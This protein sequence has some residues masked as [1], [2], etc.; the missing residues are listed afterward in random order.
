MQRKRYLLMWL[1]GVLPCLLLATLASPL[2]AQPAGTT[3]GSWTDPSGSGLTIKF[4]TPNTYE[5]CTS[6]DDRLYTEGIPANWSLTG[7]VDVYWAIP[8]PSGGTTFEKIR[9]YP[10]AQNGNLDLTIT[11]P[12]ASTWPDLSSAGNPLRE[13][14]VS[15]SILVR[16]Q[17]RREVSW[18]GNDLTGA[19]SILGP[20]QVWDVICLLPPNGNTPTPTPTNTPT[21]GTAALGDRVWNDTNRNGVQ[22]IGEPGVGGVTVELLATCTGSTVLATR[23]TNVNG[24]YLFNNLTAGQYRVR[25]TLPSGFSAFSPKDAIA[26]DD[27]DSDVN[28]V[29]VTDCITLNNGEQNYRVDAGLLSGA[30]TPTPTN[31]TV[32]PLGS[33]GDRVWRDNNGNGVQDSGEPGVAGISV[34]L[35]NCTGAILSTTTTDSNGI[36][37]FPNLNAGCYIV[38]FVNISGFTISPANQGGND[39]LDSDVTQQ[40]SVTP[41]I[42]NGQTDPITLGQGENN[43]TIDAGLVPLQPVLGSIGDRVWRDDNQN[44]I[45]NAGEPGIPGV[46]VQLKDCNGNV[47][48][49]DI[50]DNN[51]IYGFSNL[52]AGCYRVTVLPNGFQISPQDQGGDD[53]RDSDINPANATTNNINLASG[54]NNPTIDA[55]LFTA[56]LVGSIGDRVWRDDDG[57]AVQDSGEPG[58]NGVT[59]VLRNPGANNT[60]EANDTVIATQVTTGDGNYLF[61]G[62]AAGRYCVDPDQNTVPAGYALTTNND[63]TTA[64]LAAGQNRTDV[65]F[66]Y[67]PQLACGLA[68]DQK[69]VVTAPP[70]SSNFSCSA[71]K[72]INEL[73][74]I[75]NGT[76]TVDVRAWKGSVGSTLLA[77]VTN[78]A[79]GAKVVVTGYAG[80]P[81]DV[82]WEIFAAGT[83]N[84]LG[85]STFHLSCSDDNMNGPEDC[86][87]IQGDGKGKT[88][89]LNLWT[90]DGM[91]GNGQRLSCSSTPTVPADSCSIVAGSGSVCNGSKPKSLTFRYTGG[92]CA[93]SNNPQSGKFT[94]SGT[95]GGGAVTIALTGK[96]ASKFS[97]TP[98]TV[99]PGQEVTIARTD[100][101][102]FP[103]D[104]K[105][106]VGGQALTIHT[107]CSQALNLG[108]IFGS[109]TLIGA[110]GRRLDTPVTFSY[111]ISNSGN[112]LSNVSLEDNFG[113]VTSAFPLATGASRTFERQ[114]TIAETITNVALVKGFLANGQM[115]SAEDRTTVTVA[116]PALSCE[117]GKPVALVFEY[118]GGSCSDTTN[119]QNGKLICSGAPGT[120]TVSVAMQKD[121]DKISVSPNAVAPGQR[122]TLAR[123][124]SREFAADTLLRVGG[125][126]L[127]IHTSCS[128]ALN[129]GDVFGSLRLVQFVPKGFPIPTASADGDPSSSIFL[130][131]ITR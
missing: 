56:T 1:I 83:T 38:R 15:P 121:A 71:A 122:F 118:T 19:P 31:T 79:P 45:Q 115:C 119:S 61:T 54:E 113:P 11:Y 55:G 13:V 109:L 72:P 43:P 7:S 30:P 67:R 125:Q 98:S 101:G 5:S 63:P 103:A 84:K 78:V 74:M 120:G 105:L 107:S 88:G 69:C 130:P 97:I 96:D 117:D 77:T 41:G 89:F 49:S 16:D 20:G 99:N 36:Y 32:A 106:Q 4:Y 2:Y 131:L 18:L 37:T 110:D 35:R 126:S 22:D 76:Q 25:F 26:D 12:P 47:L 129:V 123:T 14:H 58:I 60:C 46:T 73:S 23:T 86:G 17:N 114:T 95:P 51:G 42:I 100:G 102:D 28:T 21:G 53:T 91:A 3:I 116:P 44:G 68:V 52:A 8:T 124:D 10:I 111:L 27:Y 92:S 87:A 94:C 40:D 81:N 64:D 6:T 34:Q 50:T 90:F 80:A 93:A 70:P 59:V 65:D 9:S 75:W 57:D 24:T 82:I 85:E 29:G 66:G 108:D 104:T 39:T 128:Q 112:S 62:L 33:L 48:Q 127:S